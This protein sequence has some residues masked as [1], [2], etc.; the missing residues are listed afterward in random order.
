MISK[1]LHSAVKDFILEHLDTLI[2]HI[3]TGNRG[4]GKSVIRQLMAEDHAGPNILQI[5]VEAYPL[6][7]SLYDQRISS[8]WCKLRGYGCGSGQAVRV[9]KSALLELAATP[10]TPAEIA[11]KGAPREWHI[12]HGL[13]VHLGGVTVAVRVAMVRAGLIHFLFNSD[14]Q[15]ITKSPPVLHGGPTLHDQLSDEAVAAG[16]MPDEAPLQLHAPRVIPQET[17]RMDAW[18]KEYHAWV[19]TALKAVRDR[20]EAEV[21]QQCPLGSPE[22]NDRVCYITKHLSPIIA[23]S[24]IISAG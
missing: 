10:L 20:A 19:A 24:Q 5:P 15:P 3:R 7:A 6:T 23:K 9:P 21:S 12:K 16:P 1:V 22:W 4:C 14:G 8:L 18:T 2:A 11:R 17:P 13:T